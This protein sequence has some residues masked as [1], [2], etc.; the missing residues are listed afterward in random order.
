[1]ITVSTLTFYPLKGAR[2]IA[3]PALELDR[4]GPRFDRRWMAITEAGRFLTQREAPELCLAEA[5]PTP[6]ALTL[7]GP[8]LPE[9]VVPVTG[10]GTPRRVRVWGSECDA[11]DQGDAAARWLG[12]LLGRS[13]RLLHLPEGEERQ[14]DPTFDPSGSPV[15]FADGYPILLIG[16]ASLAALNGA[17]VEPVPMNRF[18]PNVVVSGSAPYEEDDWRRFT[19]G[20]LPF[21]GVKRC[22]R[23][24]VTT[25]DQ[26]SAT[27]HEEPLRTLS[28]LR[29][30]EHGALFGMNVVHRARGTIAVG[31]A[32][33]V[34]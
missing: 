3:T 4:Y 21:D 7:R 10:D 31:D 12:D 27:R 33:V 30:G 9:L 15:S 6:E 22:A 18:R 13:A 24:V 19:I 5:I 23:C 17:L 32:V 16:E 11:R 8:G 29:R 14:T 28:T 34:G 25:V 26:Q 1:M 20:G 2:G